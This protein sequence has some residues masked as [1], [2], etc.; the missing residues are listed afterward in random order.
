M[1]EVIEEFGFL[2]FFANSVPGFSLEEH[3]APSAWYIYGKSWKVWEY[4]GPV[5][6][7]CGCAYG[8]FF[9]GKAAFVSREFFGDLAN[10]RRDGYDYEGR[11]NDG[12]A[13]ER[14]RVLY[15]LLAANAPIASRA[16]KA[17][18]GYGKEG[19]KGFDAAISKLQAQCYALISDFVYDI[20]KDGKPY[21]IG[22]AKYS[23]PE[24]FFGTEYCDSF[25]GRD[26]RE[27]YERLFEHLR[28]LFPSA[29]EKAIKKV[30]K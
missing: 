12:L 2:P 9:G 20:S 16:L 7:E 1:I 25:Y 24:A 28:E 8:K 13:G 15:D 26:V 14:E 5:I 22:V 19:R 29:S 10:Y 11:V 23:T 17:L 3:V 21:G 4:K 27:S 18:G 6:R 30:L